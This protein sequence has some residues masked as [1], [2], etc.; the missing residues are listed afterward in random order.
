MYD[1][2][3]IIIS[4]PIRIKLSLDVCPKLDGDLGNMWNVYCASIFYI[5]VY[6]MV[7]TRPNINQT[8]WAVRNFMSNVGKEK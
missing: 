5:L 2:K 6:V 1:Y 4:L 7:Y 8:T 3:P